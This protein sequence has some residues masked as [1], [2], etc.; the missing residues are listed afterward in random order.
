MNFFGY[1]RSL[2][3]T[4]QVDKAVTSAT[5]LCTPSKNFLAYIYLCLLY[6]FWHLYATTRS[7]FLMH[8]LPVLVN[9][10]ARVTRSHRGRRWPG[11]FLGNRANVSGDHDSWRPVLQ[12]RL[13]FRTQLIQERLA[14]FLVCD[15]SRFRGIGREIYDPRRSQ[16][17]RIIVDRFQ[18]VTLSSALF[19]LCKVSFSLLVGTRVA[20]L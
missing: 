10:G 13:A 8:R 19:L 5:T 1:Y 20:V 18:N 4:C 16:N 6:S 3:F 17:W 2:P 12:S 14:R 7:K 11:S 15:Y 9:E